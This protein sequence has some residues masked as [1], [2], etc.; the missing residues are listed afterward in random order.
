M[1]QK[2]NFKENISCHFYHPD[3]ISMG[4][5]L[6]IFS[7]PN[8]SEMP[9]TPFHKCQQQQTKTFIPRKDCENHDGVQTLHHHWCQASHSEILQ[10]DY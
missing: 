1:V 4:K 9:L 6:L 3:F 5:K 7:K 2:N 8:F 10:N